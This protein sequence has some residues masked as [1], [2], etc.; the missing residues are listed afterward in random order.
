MTAFGKLYLSL[1]TFWNRFDCN[2]SFIRIF[3]CASLAYCTGYYR[4]VVWT[5]NFSGCI[6]SGKRCSQERFYLEPGS[7]KE[8]DNTGKVYI[9]RKFGILLLNRYEGQCVSKCFDVETYCQSR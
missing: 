7:K 4:T 2:F 5:W 9:V 1:Y 3:Q 8:F 6:N